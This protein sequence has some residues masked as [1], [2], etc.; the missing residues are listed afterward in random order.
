MA[1][2]KTQKKKIEKKTQKNTKNQSYG[3]EIWHTF[4]GSKYKVAREKWAK[5]EDKKIE[6]IDKIEKSKKVSLVEL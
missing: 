5:S 1:E 4:V 2:T 6:K 3:A